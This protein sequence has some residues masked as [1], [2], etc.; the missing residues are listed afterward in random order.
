M[1]CQAQYLEQANLPE[2]RNLRARDRTETEYEMIVGAHKSMCAE[3]RS[4]AFVLPD[5]SLRA[6][7]DQHF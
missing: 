4:E 3:G 2:R 5:V 6:T 1:N 7:Y